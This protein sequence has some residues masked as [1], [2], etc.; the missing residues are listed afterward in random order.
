MQLTETPRALTE[1]GLYS[2]V[3]HVS[4][5][6]ESNQ[7]SPEE[8]NY[9][10]GAV[11]T[12]HDLGLVSARV[13]SPRRQGALPKRGNEH[14]RGM[15]ATAGVFQCT[16]MDFDWSANHMPPTLRRY[17]F[18]SNGSFIGIVQR[19]LLRPR[20]NQINLFLFNFFLK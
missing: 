11:K 3:H 17:G 19:T 1:N 8:R 14:A 16:I 2:S 5:L 9:A 20:I 15:A 12:Q 7:V 6:S 13:T 18:R 4:L 10:P